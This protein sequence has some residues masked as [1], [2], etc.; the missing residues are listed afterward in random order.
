MQRSICGLLLMFCVTAAVGAESIAT[1]Y[2]N[3]SANQSEDRVE[4]SFENSFVASVEAGSVSLSRITPKGA[5]RIRHHSKMVARLA[6]PFR[7][8]AFNHLPQ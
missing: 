2:G 4:V 5:Q 1:R 7:V 3:V 8:P 6:L